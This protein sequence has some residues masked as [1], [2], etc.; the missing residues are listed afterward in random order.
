MSGN[1]QFDY[2]ARRPQMYDTKSREQKAMRM[3]K[4]LGHYFGHS[5]LKKLK[6]L[7]VGASTGIIDNVLAKNFDSVTGIDIDKVALDY[8]KTKYKRTNLKFQLGDAM[9]LKF[10]DNSFDIVICAHVYEH[11]PNSQKM[12]L[13]IYRVLKPKG[14]CYLAAVNSLWPMEPHYDLLF[15]SWLPK[16]L[17]NIYVRIFGKAEKYH[18]TP[19]NPWQLSHMIY[20]LRFRI[21]DYTEK[22]IKNPEFFGYP[23]S[24]KLLFPVSFLAKYVSPTLFWLLEKYE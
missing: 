2:A 24:W 10:K 8:A 17:A 14:V 16:D 4:T 13:E 9:K 7:D 1:Y 19:R 18:E 6:V 22:I 21:Y 20:D 3:V 11:V 15:L 12:F 23:K 5:K